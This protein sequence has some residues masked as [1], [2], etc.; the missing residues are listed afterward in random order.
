M[1]KET[2]F[3]DLFSQS[4]LRL[5]ATRTA[6]CKLLMESSNHP[7]AAEIY[8]ELKKDY[9]SLSMATVY[10]TLN[11]LV[12]LGVISELGYIGDDTLHYETRNHDHANL[13][14]VRCHTIVDVEGIEFE[15]VE[16]KI[17]D[18]TNYQVLGS[19]VL[20]YGFCPTC[21]ANETTISNQKERKNKETI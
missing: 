19:R 10:N 3:T 9:P 16:K 12:E 20:F 21:K 18:K 14:C 8:A 7:T 2:D 5:T 1:N 6:I 17:S 15:H 13:A 11:T 4:G